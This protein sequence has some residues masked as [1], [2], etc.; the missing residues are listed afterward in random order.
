[1]K[2]SKL[3]TGCAVAAA[4]MAFGHTTS[5][6]EPA[7]MDDS[8]VEV[9][10]HLVVLDHGPAMMGLEVVS[11]APAALSQADESISCL[12]EHVHQAPNGPV[13]IVRAVDECSLR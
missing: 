7:P 13:M 9:V 8:C 12:S 10:H 1:M 6:A 5:A 4:L 11:C 3:M 2:I